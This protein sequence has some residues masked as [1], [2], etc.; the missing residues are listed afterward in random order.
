M[1]LVKMAVQAVVV[2]TTIYLPVRM[3]RQVVEIHKATMV[4]LA[5]QTQRLVVVA[6][7]AVLGWLVLMRHQQAPAVMVVMEQHLP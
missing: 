4:E 3:G 5:T 7:V 6:V 1:P 2:D